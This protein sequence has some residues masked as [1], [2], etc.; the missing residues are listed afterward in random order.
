MKFKFDN[1]GPSGRGTGRIRYS[2]YSNEIP[3][4]YLGSVEG[5]KKSWRNESDLLNLTREQR[6]GAPTYQTRQEA[7][8]T[9]IGSKA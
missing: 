1:D 9:L 3:S 4:K 8:E 2:V 5:H 7:A 6:A